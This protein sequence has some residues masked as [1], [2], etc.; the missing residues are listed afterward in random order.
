MKSLLCR[1]YLSNSTY[2][3]RLV[4]VLALVKSSNELHLAPNLEFL[5]DISYRLIVCGLS[6][7][8]P[9]SLFGSIGRK[10]NFEE[11]NDRFGNKA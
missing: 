5:L 2:F 3:V 8:E 11:V 10:P 1:D 6:E 9:I 4:H 7:V